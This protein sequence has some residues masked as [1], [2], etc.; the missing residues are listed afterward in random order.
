MASSTAAEIAG[1]DAQAEREGQ[2][3]Q[4]GQRADEQTGTD[5]FERQIKHVLPDLVGAQHMVVRRQ[6][7]QARRHQAG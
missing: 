7:N 2:H 6:R 3:D 1:G 4:S 5:R